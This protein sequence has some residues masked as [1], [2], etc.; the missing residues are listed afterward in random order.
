MYRTWLMT[1]RLPPVRSS[2]W[3]GGAEPEGRGLADALEIGAAL[4]RAARIPSREVVGLEHVVAR[5]GGKEA[6]EIGQRDEALL[7]ARLERRPAACV[8]FRPEEVHARSEE[9]RLAAR[10]AEAV[11][12][13]ADGAGRVHPDD[14]AVAHL[15]RHRVAAVQARGVHAHGFP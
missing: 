5:L 4:R 8:L 3:I 15:Q 7:G 10:R 13:V 11:V 2:S 1:A 14:A 12:E 9:L 6:R